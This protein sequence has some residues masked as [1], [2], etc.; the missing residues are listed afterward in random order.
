MTAPLWYR[1]RSARWALLIG[2]FLRLQAMVWFQQGGCLRDECTYLKLA[3]QFADG[4]GMNPSQRG[5]L[6]A[7]GYPFVASL[8]DRVFGFAEGIAPVQTLGF[9]VALVLA[10]GLAA[11]TQ[12]DAGKPNRAQAAGR[13]AIWLLALSPTLVFFSGRFWSETVYT[14]LLIGALAGLDW[15]RRGHWAR[16][17]VPGALVGACVLF[18]GVAT[19]M[20]PIF[21]L[22]LLWGRWREGRAWIGASTLIVAAVLVVA[23]YSAHASKKFGG[24]VIS[25]RTL[26]QMMWLGNND[27]PPITFDWGSGLVSATRFNAVTAQGRDHCDLELTPTDWDDCETQRGKDWIA[28]NPTEFATRIPLRLAQL[29]NPNSFLTRHVRLKHWTMHPAVSEPLLLSVVVW[30]YLAVLG[31]TVG[32]FARGR[33]WYLVVTLMIVGYHVAAVGLLAGLTRYRVPLDALWLIWAA[34]AL[35]DPKATLQALEGWRLWALSALTLLLVPLLTW[36]L[37]PGF[38]GR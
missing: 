10:Y 33:G 19:Y 17:L 4:Q 5:W 24:Q 12:L 8:S 7:P 13:W 23:P 1:D 3:R 11:R 35:A 29:F 6:W 25:D 38:V 16:A 21:C 26:G 36:F 18:R 37:V 32:A 31:G 20:L 14:T 9:L 28:E 2:L 22:G 34:S 15:T 30:S 27:Y